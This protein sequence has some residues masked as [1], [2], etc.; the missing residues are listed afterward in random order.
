VVGT[1]VVEGGKGG[2]G[3]GGGKGGGGGE[4]EEKKKTLLAAMAK[5][6]GLQK[7]S[8]NTMKA[9]MQHTLA[10]ISHVINLV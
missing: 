3:G 5:L 4:E 1:G 8:A 9:K 2:G 7:S 10:I 6:A